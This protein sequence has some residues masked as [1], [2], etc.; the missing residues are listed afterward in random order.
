MNDTEYVNSEYENIPC[1]N[2]PQGMALM[3]FFIGGAGNGVFDFSSISGHLTS[4]YR[5][6]KMSRKYSR[7]RA[8]LFIRSHLIGCISSNIL[9]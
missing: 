2:A 4:F 3:S 5:S 9:G 8:P 1:F 6:L 7:M